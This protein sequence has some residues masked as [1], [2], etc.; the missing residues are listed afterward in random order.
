MKINLKRAYDA[1][2][3][4]DGFRVL[5]DRLWPRGISKDK[6]KIDLWLKEIAPSE[7]LR[8]WFSHDP[9][10][11]EEFKSHYFEELEGKGEYLSRLLGGAKRDTV[12]LVYSS[13]EKEHN[14]AIA[15]REYLEKEVIHRKAA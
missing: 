12:T 15:L 14:N 13:K 1:P 11:W 9:E 10:R 7:G 6:L 8:K 3:R 4:G 5:V 2:S